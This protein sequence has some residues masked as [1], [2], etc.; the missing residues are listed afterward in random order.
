VS[1]PIKRNETRVGAPDEIK[2]K[3]IEMLWPTEREAQ[4]GEIIKP[5]WERTQ[6]NV[7]MTFDLYS[8][9]YD[10]NIDLYSSISGMDMISAIN[11]VMKPK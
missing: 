8:F 4:E 1:T 10:L 2:G 6:I 7:C 9:I 5:Q 11:F 3:E